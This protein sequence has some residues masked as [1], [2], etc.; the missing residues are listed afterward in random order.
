MAFLSMPREMARDLHAFLLMAVAGAPG[1]S[2][3]LDNLS[4]ATEH[5][6]VALDIGREDSIKIPEY[7]I[8]GIK[9]AIR[10]SK[11]ILSDKDIRQCNISE[12]ER[13]I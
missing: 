13:S 3:T 9:D 6:G 1:F 12:I 5:V 4:M 2:K 10:D 8:P 7:Q 11:E